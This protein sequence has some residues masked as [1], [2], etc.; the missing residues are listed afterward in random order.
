MR[1]LVLAIAGEFRRATSA[2]HRYERLKHRA[3]TC[4]DTTVDTA[5]QIFVEFYSDE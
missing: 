5:R 2:T 1:A 4:G 3:R